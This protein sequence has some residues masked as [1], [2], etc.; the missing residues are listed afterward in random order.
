MNSEIYLR[1]I[2]NNYLLLL[3]TFCPSFTRKFFVCLFRPNR[4]SIARHLRHLFVTGFVKIILTTV[5]NKNRIKFIVLIFRVI[6]KEVL[7]KVLPQIQRRQWWKKWNLFIFYGGNFLR[8]FVYLL[9]PR[10]LAKNTRLSHEMTQ[11][12]L[13]IAHLAISMKPTPLLEEVSW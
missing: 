11:F 6:V 1:N 7:L 3:L 8:H 2:T 10:A 13:K 4:T 9:F 5:M 12:V